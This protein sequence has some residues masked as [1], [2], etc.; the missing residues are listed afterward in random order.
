MLDM[1]R[2]KGPRVTTTALLYFL[3]QD[4]VNYRSKRLSSVR[5]LAV[6][7]PTAEG[8]K[9]PEVYLEARSRSCLKPTYAPPFLTDRRRSIK[10]TYT[11][12]RKEP[13]RP[14][15]CACDRGSTV[16]HF[17]TCHSLMPRGHL[18]LE[19]FLSQQSSFGG[20]FHH[21]MVT[22]SKVVCRATPTSRQVTRQD[23]RTT[24]RSCRCQNCRPGTRNKP[25]GPPPQSFL[26]PSPSIH[27]PSVERHIHADRCVAP[28]S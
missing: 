26:P 27:L 7:R 18:F 9:V 10:A 28:N 6:R 17:S 1:R 19:I 22:T 14:R 11:T 5:R 13:L 12:S 16:A 3:I 25:Q 2:Q 20:Q 8:D 21:S 4:L 15:A 24:T 23:F